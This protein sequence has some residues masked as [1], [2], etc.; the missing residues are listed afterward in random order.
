VRGQRQR[1]TYL[2]GGI[3][4]RA[5]ELVDSDQERQV[6]MLEEI[7]RG[8]AVLQTSAVHQDDRADRAAHQVVPHEPES[9]LTRR[10]E[11]IEHQILIEG[12]PAEV[13]RDRGGPLVRGGVD[14]V[15][16]GG[17]VGDHRLG[18]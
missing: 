12:D 10:S 1:F 2:G 3:P 16:A 7:D 9:A 15:D 17:G 6:A 4:W 13:H 5:V 18:P 8:E 14:H 11:Q